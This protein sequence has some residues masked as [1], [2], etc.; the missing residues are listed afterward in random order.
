[1]YIRNAD[2][3]TPRPLLFDSNA[4]S[5]GM[6]AVDLILDPEKIYGEYI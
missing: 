2:P 6:T 1:M 4:E 3:S 5:V